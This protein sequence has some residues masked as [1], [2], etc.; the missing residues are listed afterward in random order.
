MIKVFVQKL[1][2]LINPNNIL[3][4]SWSD[5]LVLISVASWVSS[6]WEEHQI[7]V[8]SSD[9]AYPLLAHSPF[10]LH[11]DS[12][13]NLSNLLQILWRCQLSQ[14]ILN[15]DSNVS[16]VSDILAVSIRIVFIL[17]FVPLLID[18]IVVISVC[19]FEAQVPIL[20]F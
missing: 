14:S 1:K 20:N 17:G 19:S 2:S 15:S 11:W 13:Q 4:L 16:F 10:T 5:L 7:V 12:L 8:L 9:I 3:L 18:F 6:K